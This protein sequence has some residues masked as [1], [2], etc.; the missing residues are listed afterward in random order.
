MGLRPCG[1]GLQSDAVDQ[2]HGGTG[3]SA[4][5]NYELGGRWRIRRGR[6][7]KSRHLYLRGPATI[8]IT[9]RGRGQASLDI[10]Y[11]GSSIAFTCEGFDKWTTFTATVPRTT[12]RPLYRDR[13]R[14]SK[15]RRSHP[16]TIFLQ[17]PASSVAQRF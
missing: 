8:T 13:V 14:L 16:L 5:A 15:R 7:L 6:H 2:A 10:K 9:D 4:P 12:R 1:C 11:R 17:E 3:M